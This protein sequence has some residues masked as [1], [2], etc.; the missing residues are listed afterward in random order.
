LKELS[1][2]QEYNPDPVN[3]VEYQL[4]DK[5]IKIDTP[6]FQYNISDKLTYSLT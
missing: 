4:G 3:V 2:P 1:K 6:L 5:G